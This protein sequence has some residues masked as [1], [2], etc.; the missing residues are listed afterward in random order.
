[1]RQ[2]AGIAMAEKKEGFLKLLGT[3]LLCAG[4]TVWAVYAVLRIWMG[5]NI[6]AQQFLPYHLAGVL[7]GLILRHR[8]FF[9]GD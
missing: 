6:T 1:M 5:W 3:I 8:W 7:P 4:V 9:S 2:W